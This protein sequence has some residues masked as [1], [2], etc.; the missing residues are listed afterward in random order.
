MTIRDSILEYL[1]QPRQLFD[2]AIIKHNGDNIVEG[3]MTGKEL[4]RLQNNWT[5]GISRI[6]IFINHENQQT[7]A[8]ITLTDVETIIATPAG[9]TK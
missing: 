1:R 2:V 4:R 5:D 6:C 9:G 3:T 8:S 7:R